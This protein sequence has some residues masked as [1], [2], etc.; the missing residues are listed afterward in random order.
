MS[1]QIQDLIN[2]NKN[3]M[4]SWKYSIKQW[5]RALENTPAEDEKQVLYWETEIRVAEEKVKMYE[6]FLNSLHGLVS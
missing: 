6:S 1:E 3:S 2:R 5:K 4:D